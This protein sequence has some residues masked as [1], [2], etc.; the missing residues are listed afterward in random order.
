MLRDVLPSS[1]M[2]ELVDGSLVNAEQARGGG[3]IQNA[4]LIVAPKATDHISRKFR[5]AI[6][7]PARRLSAEASECGRAVSALALAVGIVLGKR[8]KKQMRRIAARRAVALVA[9]AHCWRYGSVSQFISNAM[10]GQDAS[11]ACFAPRRYAVSPAADGQF[12][13][14]ALFVALSSDVR[15]EAIF[16]RLTHIANFTTG[17]AWVNA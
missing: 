10:R 1:A 14:P 6:E 3:L 7:F 12:P 15:P 16:E 13:R 4:S 8:A 11:P 5:M 2:N 17:S 9:N